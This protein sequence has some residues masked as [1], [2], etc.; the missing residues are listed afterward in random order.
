MVLR[1]PHPR[2][3]SAIGLIAAVLVVSFLAFHRAFAPIAVLDP[4]LQVLTVRTL[5]SPKDHFY[6]GNQAE[7][8][9]RD[10]LRNR[11]GLTNVAPLND[12][13]RAVTSRYPQ[14]ASILVMT[15]K[16]DARNGDLDGIQGELVDRSGKVLPVS[17]M[18][19]RN[20]PKLPRFGAWFLG[21][22]LMAPGDYRLRLNREDQATN[23]SC[24]AET[25]FMYLCPAPSHRQTP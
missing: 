16:W 9:A 25:R 3:P 14:G 19:S 17:S 2:L 18:C 4:R 22:G 7:G 10:F 15:F 6:V 11:V 20:N 23:K 21:A 13:G 24:L 1:F 8:Y 5:R 12:I